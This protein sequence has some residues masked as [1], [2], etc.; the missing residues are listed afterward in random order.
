MP[1]P[2]DD[3]E[4]RLISLTFKGKI[5]L[6]EKLRWKVTEKDL[7]CKMQ[8]DTIPESEFPKSKG[9]FSLESPSNSSSHPASE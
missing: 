9:P 5:W 8:D 6:G 3:K 1:Y 2:K 4:I 7:Q